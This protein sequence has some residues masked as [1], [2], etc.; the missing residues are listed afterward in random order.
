MLIRILFSKYCKIINKN[1]EKNISKT[2]FCIHILTSDFKHIF[3]FLICFV[4]GLC[5][6]N[7]SR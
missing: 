3:E 1:F 2:I 6:S 5:A 7:E 4:C